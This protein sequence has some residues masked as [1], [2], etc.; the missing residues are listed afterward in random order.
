METMQETESVSCEQFWAVEKIL[1]DWCR[2]LRLKKIIGI[3]FPITIYWVYLK[4]KK[5]S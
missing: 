3:R 4:E 5:E 2:K 1:S